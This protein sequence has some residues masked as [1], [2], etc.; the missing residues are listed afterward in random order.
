[1]AAGRLAFSLRFPGE[2]RPGWKEGKLLSLP[3]TDPSLLIAAEGGVCLPEPVAMEIVGQKRV[4]L[5]GVAIV[6][7]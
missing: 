4:V 3:S 7:L 5:C 6:R 1:M 2:E